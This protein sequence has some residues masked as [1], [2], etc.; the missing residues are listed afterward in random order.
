MKY[1]YVLRTFRLGD[2]MLILL[3]SQFNPLNLV[4]SSSYKYSVKLGN[5]D[6]VQNSKQIKLDR[7]FSYSAE[8]L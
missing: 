3:K 7:I 5:I 1:T 6:L 2:V 4:V 8:I